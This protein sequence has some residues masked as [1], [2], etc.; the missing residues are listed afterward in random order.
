[1]SPGRNSV[2]VETYSR[3]RANGNVIRAV[4]SRWRNSP[5]TRVKIS[6][7]PAPASPIGVIQGPIEPERGQ[8]LPGVTLNLP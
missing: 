6:N 3:M 1:M 7:G 2:K 8:F 5:L 4:E